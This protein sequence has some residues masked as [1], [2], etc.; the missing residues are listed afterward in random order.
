MINLILLAIEQQGTSRGTP[1][2][3]IEVTDCGLV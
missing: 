3:K 1:K 2:S